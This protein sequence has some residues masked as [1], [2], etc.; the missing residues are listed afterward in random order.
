MNFSRARQLTAASYQDKP[1]REHSGRIVNRSN[2]P[3]RKLGTTF[4]GN[5]FIQLNYNKSDYNEELFHCVSVS[6][7]LKAPAH[8][9]DKSVVWIQKD[10]S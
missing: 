4:L 8:D 5:R 6:F 2:F 3:Q 7:I 10:N 9:T 1:N